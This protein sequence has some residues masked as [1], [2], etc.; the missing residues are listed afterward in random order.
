VIGKARGDIAGRAN[1]ACANGV[2]DGDRDAK[3]YAQDLQELAAFFVRVSCAER[4]VGGK[5]VTGSGQCVVSGK[6][7]V[8]CHDTRKL[9][10][11]SRPG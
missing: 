2:T 3:A 1:D 5:R 9:Q 6:A 10:I 7:F 8:T 11:E 4:R